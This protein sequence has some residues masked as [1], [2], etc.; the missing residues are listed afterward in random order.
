VEFVSTSPPLIRVGRREKDE[1]SLGYEHIQLDLISAT[2]AEA[3]AVTGAQVRNFC[4]GP[5]D[6]APGDR[7][8][9]H[10]LVEFDTPPDDEAVFLNALDTGLAVRHPF[11]AGMR[12][13]DAVLLPPRLTVLSAGTID[14]WV[15][16]TRQFGQGKFLHLHNDRVAIDALLAAA[17]A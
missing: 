3:A 1:I 2:L 11:Y 10:W 7:K 4:L 16:E 17:R 14:R 9:Y 12:T 5:A 8:A 13:D 6:T 15:L